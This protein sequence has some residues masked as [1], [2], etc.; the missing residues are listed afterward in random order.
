MKK[1]I[2]HIKV[3]DCGLAFKIAEAL[4]KDGEYSVEFFDRDMYGN[5]LKEL[6]DSNAPVIDLRIFYKED[7]SPLPVGFT[8]EDKAD[9][10]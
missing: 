3:H 7:F 8:G 5:P 9:E 6:S 10:V 1:F 4:E 2:D